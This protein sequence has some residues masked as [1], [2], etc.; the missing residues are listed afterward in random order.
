M[1]YLREARGHVS[2]N[3]LAG[4]ESIF[5]RIG[6]PKSYFCVLWRSNNDSDWIKSAIHSTV[7]NL[8]KYYEIL[9]EGKPHSIMPYYLV[10]NRPLPLPLINFLIFCQPGHSFPTP[11]PLPLPLINFLI[12][13]IKRAG[14]FVTHY[15]CLQECGRISNSVS[16]LKCTTS[17]VSK[18]A[19]ENKKVNRRGMSNPITEFNYRPK[20]FRTRIGLT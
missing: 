7:F 17:H 9:S 10:P 8:A 15:I 16:A 18:D 14:G 6:Y 4:A 2:L 13:K 11:H 1:F 19:A 12:L 5:I 3:N 20:E